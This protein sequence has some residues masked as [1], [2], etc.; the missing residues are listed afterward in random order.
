[1]Q[2]W[3]QHVYSDKG[4]GPDFS[5]KNVRQDW[6]WVDRQNGVNWGPWKLGRNL[7][8]HSHHLHLH[9]ECFNKK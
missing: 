8:F 4:A 5:K 6:S 9:S 3:Q 7:N 2:E 1:M